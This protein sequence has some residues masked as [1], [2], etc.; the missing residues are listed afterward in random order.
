M[1]MDCYLRV[2]AML[3]CYRGL[4]HCGLDPGESPSVGLRPTSLVAW[5]FTKTRDGLFVVGKKND[6]LSCIGR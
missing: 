4:F 6:P 2:A 5:C 3:A 1:P